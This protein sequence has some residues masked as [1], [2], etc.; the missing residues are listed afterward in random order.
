M[1]PKKTVSAALLVFVAASVLYLVSGSGGSAPADAPRAAPTDTRVVAYYFHGTVRCRTCLAI[2]STAR[3][4][5]QRELA[6]DFESGAIQWQTVD[7]EQPENE[8]FAREFQLTGATLVLVKEAEGRAERWDKLDRVW[9]LIGN[10]AEFGEYVL[11]RTRGYLR[12]S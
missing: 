9:E 1:S 10:D 7:Y 4:V 5:L 11:N 12:E 2:E 3:E 8:H 6:G